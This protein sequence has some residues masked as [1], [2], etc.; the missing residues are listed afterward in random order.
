MMPNI[1]YSRTYQVRRHLWR[2]IIV[3]TPTAGYF[4][5]WQWQEPNDTH[6]FEILCYAEKPPTELFTIA[7]RDEKAALADYRLQL[8]PGDLDYPRYNSIP[9]RHSFNHLMPPVPIKPIRGK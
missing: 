7:S 9:T 8:M 1:Y 4:T 2:M 5:R 3:G 6:W